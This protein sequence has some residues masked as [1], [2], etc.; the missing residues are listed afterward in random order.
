MPSSVAPRRHNG[1]LL[2]SQQ[3]R[4]SLVPPYS[5]SL[6]DEAIDLARHAGLDL[7]PWQQLALTHMLGTRP[8]GKWASFEVGI[9][10]PRQNGKGAIL[11]ARE[12]AGLFLFGE[13][14]IVHS[15]HL[16]D[17]SLEA[18]RRLLFWIE[19]NPD[20]SKRVKRI[21][22]SHGEEGI[23]LN[24]G[25]RIRFRTRTK[26]GGR[27]LSGTTVI[28]DE[29]MEIAQAAHGALFPI[30]SAQPNPQIIYTGSAVDEN[31]HEHG[32][33]LAR[34]RERGIAGKD[35]SL[36][37]MEWSIDRDEYEKHPEIAHDPV[38]WAQA[39][40]SFGFRITQEYIENERR[41]L[42]E[43]TFVVERGGIGYYPRTDQQTLRLISDEQYKS[44]ID[45][46]SEAADPVC[47]A[48]DVTP[49][50]SRAAIGAAGDCAK[51]RGVHIEV[52]DHRRG[53]DWVVARAI[54]LEKSHQPRG[55]ICD[56]SGPAASLMPAFSAAGIEVTPIS[57]RE[58]AQAC[59]MIVDGFGGEAPDAADPD[60]RVHHLDTPELAAAINGAQKK[61]AGDGPF[62]FSRSSSL[63]DISPLVSVT[64]ARWGLATIEPPKK[65]NRD[66]YRIRRL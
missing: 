3:P 43:R 24:R 41:A 7:D 65:L 57:R 50:R 64:L 40:P 32:L 39:N 52:I 60:G 38:Y 25:Q 15:A 23:E 44:R 2:G 37:Y 5:I 27:G 12:L 14:L 20:F 33:V 61:N 18:F 45:L 8:D 30:M 1:R 56:A 63:A 26:G 42:S 46:K 13:R 51:G 34:L 59:G 22:R 58:Y 62:I 10:V 55:W 54:E 9:T 36:M 53:T 29:S 66:V 19:N 35:P 16:F 28:L 47:F 11:E 48:F 6:G 4:I 31:V 17:T 49:D 21:S